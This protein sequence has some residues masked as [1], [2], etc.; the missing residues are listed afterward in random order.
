MRECHVNNEYNKFYNELGFKER[1]QV[2]HKDILYCI[3][4]EKT[5]NTVTRQMVNPAFQSRSRLRDEGHA[6][7]I[8][9]SAV[10]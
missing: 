7:S 5:G 4:G 10:N 6:T 9:S 1:S 8:S 2:S 3:P